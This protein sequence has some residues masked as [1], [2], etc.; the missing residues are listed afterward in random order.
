MPTVTYPLLTVVDDSGNVV[1][2]ATVAIASVK[3]KAGVDIATPGATIFSSGANVS[4]DYDAE[5]RGE[6]WIV[7]TVSKAGSTFTG[8]NAAPAFYLS[9]DSGRI[10]VAVGSR[11]PTTSYVAPFNPTDYARDNVAPTWFEGFP[12]A[13][14]VLGSTASSVIVSGLPADKEYIKQRLGDQPSREWRRI[15]GQTYDSGTGRYTFAL[16]VVVM[17][18]DD[19]TKAFSDVPAI[20]SVILMGP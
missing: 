14:V 19:E 7:L 2:G 15:Q 13:T 16:G 8:T 20:G 5:T 1:S 17:P 3:D 12:G 10:D 6:A 4:V 9:R 18:L 11:L